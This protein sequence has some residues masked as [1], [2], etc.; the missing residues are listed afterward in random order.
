MK[1]FEEIKSLSF[2]YHITFITHTHTHNNSF[3]LYYTLPL[4]MYNVHCIAF[5]VP[6]CTKSDSDLKPVNR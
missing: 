1:I 4:Y 5:N 3:K 2:L 6:S